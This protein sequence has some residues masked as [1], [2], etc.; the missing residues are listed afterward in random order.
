MHSSYWRGEYGFETWAKLKEHVESEALA[1]GPVS[2]KASQFLDLACLNYETDSPRRIQTAQRMIEEDPELATVNVYTAAVVGDADILREMLLDDPTLATQRGGPRDWEPLLYLC[3]GRLSVTP[4]RDTPAAAEVLLEYGGNPNGHFLGEDTYRFT[5]LTGAIGEGEAGL[6]NQPPHRHAPELARLL[7]DAGADPN[8]GQ[9]LYNSMFTPGNTWIE[10]LLGYG[11]KPS[12]LVNWKTKHPTRIMDFLLGHATKQGML[13]RVRL[14][15][16]HGADARSLDHYNRRVHHANALL[17]GHAE[18]AEML[19]EHGAEPAA[20]SARDLF[21]VACM[22]ADRGSAT[23]LLSDQAELLHD[24]SLLCDAAAQGR[25]DAVGLLLDLG[26]NPDVSDSGGGTALHQAA[27]RGYTQIAQLLLDHGARF[28][29]DE[30]HDATPVGWADYAGNGQMSD[31]L[32][33]RCDDVFDL[34]THGRAESLA[35]ILKQDPAL[36]S[37]P[38]PAGNSPVHYLRV[39]TIHGGAVI[40]LLVEHG[41]DL[42]AVNSSGDTALDRALDGDS[43]ELAGLL[44]A[45]GAQRSS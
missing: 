19:T 27:W 23:S 7:L 25:A 4:S 35:R 42:N 29:R 34:V 17:N 31:F 2:S 8:D 15:L 12:D 44:R 41:A 1:S 45:R 30:T 14:L 3:Y 9:G 43:R 16:E 24:A 26:A 22:S 33:D 40:D 13:E 36:A 10:L 18:V 38:D 5:A 11:L 37:R 21:R 32:L 39:D 28:L 20:F 6:K